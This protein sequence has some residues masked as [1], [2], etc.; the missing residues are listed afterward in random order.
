MS[1]KPINRQK[2]PE[3]RVVNNVMTKI[4]SGTVTMKPK[5]LFVA[6]SV[7]TVV[8]IAASSILSVFLIALIR[9]ATRTH[10]PMGE[11]RLQELVSSFPWIALVFA[12]A[13]LLGG[14][15]LLRR[16]EF[17]YKK[18][19]FLIASFFAGALILAA[20]LVDITGIG[21]TWFRQG[22]GRYLVPRYGNQI[23]GIPG[24]GQ[25]FWKRNR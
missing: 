16:Y 11:Y 20:L 5:F 9:F 1:K 3:S 2:K 25:G 15:L 19:F 12:V 18:N 6:G 13:G 7:L 17:V 23:N 10:G 22:P 14:I 24:Q 8:G 4:E 21:D